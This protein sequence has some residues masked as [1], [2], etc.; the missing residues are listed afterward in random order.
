[1]ERYVVARSDEIAPLELMRR[2]STAPARIFKLPGGSLAAGAVA[3]VVLLDPERT[4]RYD[5]AKGY[6]KSRNSPWAGQE[7][8][9]RP[10]ATLVG[11]RLVY[12]V[13]R[14]VLMP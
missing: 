5:P 4:W 11:G 14:G 9:G 2:F 6:S 1:M 10:V 8:T 12:H 7:L 3:D 13:D